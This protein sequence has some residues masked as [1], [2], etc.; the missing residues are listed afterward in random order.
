[1]L[2]KIINI[3]YSHNDYK[4]VW[5]IYFGQ[6]EKY[7]SLFDKNVIFVDKVTQGVPKNW[8]QIIYDDQRSY[9]D[10]LIECFNQI[11]YNDICFFAHEDMFLYDF[12]NINKISKYADTM[13]SKEG[14]I[15]K[16][17]QFDF[18]KMIKGGEFNSQRTD[19]DETLFSLDLSSKW[20]FSIQPS[21]WNIKRFIKLLENHKGQNIWEFEEK[22]QKTC[23]KIK[24]KGAYCDSGGKKSGKYH[25]DNDIYPYVA[26]AIV[27]GNWNFEEYKEILMPILEKY[28]IDFNVRGFGKC[29]Y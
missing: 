6:Q 9:V 26:T 27:K 4:D 17:N 16:R 1:M 8:Q 23:K 28:K 20:I 2:N 10:R 18:I 11:H 3:L 29:K 21:F 22:S 7:F 25:W 5:P 19:I 14:K 24:I 12:P 13:F 15:L